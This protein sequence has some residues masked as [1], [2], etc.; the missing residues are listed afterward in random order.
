[1]QLRAISQ[2]HAVARTTYSYIQ[3]INYEQLH[4]QLKDLELGGRCIRFT[5]QTEP[6]EG[7]PVRLGWGSP[8]IKATP[9]LT[10][11]FCYGT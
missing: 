11:Y 6:E 2:N 10:E 1:M 3:L 4:K 8:R 7:S 5:S 9:N